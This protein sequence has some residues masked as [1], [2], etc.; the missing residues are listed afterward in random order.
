VIEFLR[1]LYYDGAGEMA[2]W[3]TASN[4]ALPEDLNAVL[5]THV[6]RVTTYCNFPSGDP[7]LLASKH[8]CT[9]GAYT[10]TDTHIHTNK[11]I[12][13]ISFDFSYD[14]Q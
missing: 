7:T 6:Q 5:N 14:I 1:L 2:H 8:T 10:H 4:I 13:K 9:H 3:L 12:N 11:Y